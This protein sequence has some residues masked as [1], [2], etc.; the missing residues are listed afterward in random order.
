MYLIFSYYCI[1]PI[2][3]LIFLRWITLRWIHTLESIT[4]F[5][6]YCVMTLSWHLGTLKLLCLQFFISIE[7][8]AFVW[9]EIIEK[10]IVRIALIRI[11]YKKMAGKKKSEKKEKKKLMEETVSKHCITIRTTVSS[12]LLC[13]IVVF[14]TY[15]HAY[16]ICSKQSTT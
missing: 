6:H 13:S 14:Y 8:L 15:S 7:F 5:W 12:L 11:F 16:F 10:N 3:L 4:Q 9:I 1:K 2:I